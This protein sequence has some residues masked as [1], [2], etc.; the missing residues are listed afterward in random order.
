M[1]EMTAQVWNTCGY[2]RLSREDGDKEE[3]N[4]VTGQK[5]LIR[6][7]LSRHPELRERGMKV[8]DGFTGSNFQRP[9]FQE[10]ISEAKAGKINCIVVKDLSRFG[11]N[12][13]EAGEYIERYF[14]F[15]GV[16]FIAINDHFD[17]MNSHVESD[18][19]LVPFKN[20][21]NEAYCRDTSVKIRSQLEI[22][23]QRG[24][25]IGSFAVFGYKKDAS[26]HHK[27]VVDEFAADVVRDIFNWK[28]DGISA[29]DIASRLTNTGIPA[30]MD[31]KL[32]QGMRYNTAF[33][34]KERSEWSAN[35]VLRIL[36]N[37]VYTGVL[38]QGKVT[39]PSYKVKRL[40]HKPREDWA[41]VENCHEAIIDPFDFEIAQ[42]VLALDTRTAQ[43]GQPVELFSGMVYC[44]EC[45]G[46]MVRK[47]VSAGGKRYAYFICAAHKNEK[48][49]Y[50]HSLRTEA[51]ENIVLES[52][53]Q[54][55]REVIDLSALLELADVA[56][57]QQAN[58][59][60][61]QARL[62]IKQK[63]L[64]RC[65]T[66][67]RSLYESLNDGILEEKEYQD[68]KST[69]LR[70][71]DEAETQID[72][73]RQEMGRE[74]VLPNHSWME[75]FR[76]HKN[77]S[78]LERRLVVSLIERVMIYRDRR[79]ELVYRWQDEFQAQ[80]ELVNQ[81]LPERRAI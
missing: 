71:R 65:H 23:R 59:R 1:E 37:P 73:L 2:V 56:K 61:L 75:Q 17:S 3:S 30:P 46:A 24:D 26:D 81:A 36:K 74:M 21:I 31:Y 79:V 78:S 20:L 27:L 7:Y 22:K 19:L 68:L 44:G 35:M 4:S 39:T 58:M 55:I 18:E 47:I 64:D 10:M 51:L 49:C 50:S 6:D 12:Y 32:A 54:H 15:L 14:P 66:L 67:L 80:S 16:R 33:R 41:V 48:T 25:F 77:I 13:L 42:R 34:I 52:L 45:G 76:K 11:R 60:K 69:Y 62:D 72:R 9:G 53:Q 43:A 70:Q 5:D 38:E 57:L 63:E 29:I 8:D 28:L 40:V